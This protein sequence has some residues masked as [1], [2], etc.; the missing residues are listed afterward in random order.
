MPAFCIGQIRVRNTEAWEQYRQR[1]GATIKQYGGEVV[2]R[3]T[4]ARI[5]SGELPYERVVV[6]Q[7]DNLES[8]NR[9]HYSPEYQ[10]LLSIREKGADVTLVLYEGEGQNKKEQVA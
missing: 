6:L 1:V 10:A 7:F 5:L 9:W 3:G 8:A 4:Q 2:F